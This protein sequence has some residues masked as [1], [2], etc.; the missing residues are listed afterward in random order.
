MSVSKLTGKVIRKLAGGISKSAHEA[1]FIQTADGAFELRKRGVNPF[2]K[3][4]FE[5]WLD[6]Q[7][8]VEGTVRE[9]IIFVEKISR[10]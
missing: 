3:S 7:V 4:P 8:I 6:K 9:N 2:M 1:L 5:S 10:A